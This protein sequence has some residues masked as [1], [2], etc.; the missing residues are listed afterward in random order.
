MDGT[1]YDSMPRH[2]Q[3]WHRLLTELDI[4]HSLDEIYLYEGMTGAATINLLFNRHYGRNATP[5]ECSRYYEAKTRYFNELPTAPI[6]PG[7][8]QV[9]NYLA[10]AGLTIILVTGSGQH[11]LIDR[12]NHDFPGIFH[13]DRMV[14]SANVNHGKP[15]PEPYLLGAAMAGVSP[16]ECIAIENAPLGVESASRSGAFTIGLTTGPIPAQKLA[17]A[18]ADIVL[19]SMQSLAD[20][21]EIILNN[22][23]HKYHPLPKL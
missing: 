16:A 19:P 7:A 10:S 15:H 11:S 23:N 20:N 21:I 9:L 13:R 17:E 18:G 5:E 4:P 22:L 14:T 12:L 3:A 1:L 8:P 2:A 6:M